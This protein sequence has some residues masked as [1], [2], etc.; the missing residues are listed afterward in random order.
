M[1]AG[2]AAAG[3]HERRLQRGHEGWAPPEVFL[4]YHASGLAPVGMRPVMG[5]RYT[6]AFEKSERRVWVEAVWKRRR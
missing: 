2:A 1:L 4:D 6:S 3:V 5:R